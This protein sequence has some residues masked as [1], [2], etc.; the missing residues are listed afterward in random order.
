MSEVVRPQD[1][2]YQYV[3][4]DWLNA[5]VIPSNQASWGIINEM[6]LEVDRRLYELIEDLN[7]SDRLIGD[8]S[9]LVN[10]YRSFEN[11]KS[12]PTLAIASVNKLIHQIESIESDNDF[13]GVVGHLARVGVDTPFTFNIMPDLKETDAYRLYVGQAGLTLPNREYYLENSDRSKSL[14]KSLQ[15]YVS[16]LA[17]DVG[18]SKQ[19][20]RHGRLAIEFENQLAKIQAPME[21]TRDID[22]S[23]NPLTIE[24][25]GELDAGIPWQA[26]LAEFG[27]TEIEHVVVG[28]VDYIKRFVKHMESFCLDLVSDMSLSEE[29]RKS[30][31]VQLKLMHYKSYLIHRVLHWAAPFCN[32]NTEMHYFDF[33]ESQVLGLKSR[34]DQWQRAVRLVDNQLGW[35]VSKNY[36]ARWYPDEAAIVMEPLVANLKVAFREILQEVPWLSEKARQLALQKLERMRAK[37][38]RPASFRRYTNLLIDERDLLENLQAISAYEVDQKIAKLSKGVDRDEWMMPAHTVNAYYNPVFN[39]VVFPAGFLQPPLFDHNAAPVENYGAI[40]AIIGHEMSHGFDDMGRRF[41]PDGQIKDW[42]KD[43]DVKCFEDRTVA[44][45][46]QYS[47]YSPIEGYSVNG[48]LTL[49]ENIADLTGLTIALRAFKIAHA[50]SKDRNQIEFDLIRDFFFSYARA[51]RWKHRDETM[52]MMVKTD[53]HSPP[54]YRVNGVVVNMSD[55]Q[56][57]FDLAPGDGLYR[58]LSQ[59]VRIW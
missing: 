14:R 26:M 49:G 48:Q 15:V 34:V 38:G 21:S 16:Q 58:P 28:P 57:A 18:R 31:A 52:M 20:F 30:S 13:F 56:L 53:P 11:R 51:W 1:D 44:L 17:I 35:I 54:E 41:G 39:E 32:S 33:Y 36:C 55:F 45:V 10:L 29:D 24:E 59:Q 6:R 46:E 9:H 37:I 8:D 27:V 42:W 43:E 3:N 25:L 40:G 12:A 50:G 5:L 7:S 2:L 4:G 19:S 23:Y 22:I 47:N